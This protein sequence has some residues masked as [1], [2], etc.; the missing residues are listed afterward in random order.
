MGNSSSSSSEG[1]LPPSDALV[2]LVYDSMKGAFSKQTH[3]VD[4][5][6]S[7]LLAALHQRLQEEQNASFAMEAVSMGDRNLSPESVERKKRKILTS[8][9][10]AG[11][12]NTE[13]ATRSNAS[14]LFLNH[15][16]Q[17]VANEDMPRLSLVSR[18]FLSAARCELLQRCEK[19]HPSL[20]LALK[21]SDGNQN[22]TWRAWRRFELE[23][24]ASMAHWPIQ[25]VDEIYGDVDVLLE[26]SKGGSMVWSGVAPLRRDE[27]GHEQRV[28]ECNWQVPH[29]SFDA[30]V[31]VRGDVFSS[32]D[33]NFPGLTS[34]H[35]WMGRQDCSTLQKTIC[36]TLYGVHSPSDDEDSEPPSPLHVQVVLRRRS[37][38]QMVTV[39]SSSEP[40]FVSGEDSG[41]PAGS[42]DVN[43]Q[44]NVCA[45][46]TRD[47]NLVA[48]LDFSLFCSPDA[49][50][51]GAKS[52][53]FSSM[54]PDPTS[55]ETNSNHTE[56]EFN[57]GFI[58][59]SEDE[60][61]DNLLTPE[62]VYVRVMRSWRW[63]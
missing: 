49:A 60:N 41:N 33:R 21:Q 31:P 19:Q 26:I 55:G 11:D 25:H 20:A 10:P 36:K 18:S 35:Y 17:F 45:V 42:Y 13:L 12:A 29:W 9:P 39:I 48:F 5:N 38:G 43:Y 59:E 54:D 61:D 3:G 51:E 44:K 57:L 1:V 52:I 58:D 56:I 50:E 27:R 24:Q 2:D 28:M 6:K 40:G 15:G 7:L 23:T 47:L 22:I 30:P 14:D 63:A 16:L 32:P 46:V 34:Y 8:G 62:D 53:K 4:V 37:T